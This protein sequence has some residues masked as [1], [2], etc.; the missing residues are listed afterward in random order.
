MSS[1]RNSTSTTKDEHDGVELFFEEASITHVLFN[2][3]GEEHY[4]ALGHSRAL[5]LRAFRLAVEVIQ[6]RG[7]SIVALGGG[8]VPQ[9]LN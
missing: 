5:G 1:A 2:L 7:A 6:T 8:D 4:G 3:Q 9:M